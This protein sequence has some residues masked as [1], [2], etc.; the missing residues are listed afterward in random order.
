MVNFDIVTFQFLL[1]LVDTIAQSLEITHVQ[2]LTANMEMQT[3]HLDIGHALGLFND[4]QHITHIY[5][6]FVLC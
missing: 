1:Q 3:Y 6:E 2:N 4:L 5:A